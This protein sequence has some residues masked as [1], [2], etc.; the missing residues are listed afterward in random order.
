MRIEYGDLGNWGSAELRSEYDPSGPVIRIN[1]RVFS[2]IAP[3]ER[4]EFLTRAIAHEFYHHLEHLG[5]IPVDVEREAAAT[6]PL[7]DS[8]PLL[9]RGAS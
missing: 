9:R 3:A 6:L 4:N 8:R 1:T 5:I 7:A 2:R